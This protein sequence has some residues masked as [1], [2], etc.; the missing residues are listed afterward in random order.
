[1]ADEDA[2]AYFPA[3]QLE[4]RVLRQGGED[5]GPQLP[6]DVIITLVGLGDGWYQAIIGE[7]QMPNP[8]HKTEAII[9]R[10]AAWNAE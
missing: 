8:V 10:I 1:M 4:R 5:A 2:F 3:S 7:N 9:D 6:A